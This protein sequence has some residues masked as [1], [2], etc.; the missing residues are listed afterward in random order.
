MCVL[1]SMFVVVCRVTHF[2]ALLC[3]LL[4][5][6]VMLSQQDA[7]RPSTAPLFPALQQSAAPLTPVLSALART[8][9]V[10]QVLLAHKVC[11]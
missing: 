6:P 4:N 9:G 7:A 10:R 1:G 8:K 2:L 5:N 11:T 3:S